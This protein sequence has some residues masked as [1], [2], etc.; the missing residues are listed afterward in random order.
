MFGLCLFFQWK[1]Q[2]PPGNLEGKKQLTQ[3][4][5]IYPYYKHILLNLPRNTRV[6]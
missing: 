6:S 2:N 5:L 3:G 4:L 1:Q